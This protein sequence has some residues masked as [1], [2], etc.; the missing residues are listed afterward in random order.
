MK[1]SLCALLVALALCCYQA[2]AAMTCPA[3]AGDMSSFVIDSESVFKL[4]LAQF[5]A[6]DAAV[7]AKMLWKTCYN[8]AVA[9]AG[10]ALIAKTLMNI[11]GACKNE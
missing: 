11:L 6:P 9:P 4:Y 3:L 2:D 10:R 8:N 7:E 5:H 1:L